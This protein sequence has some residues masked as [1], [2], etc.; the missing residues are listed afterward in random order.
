MKILYHHRTL[1]DGAEGIHIAEMVAAFRSLG[2][3]VHV[4]SLAG[5]EGLPAREEL[6]GRLKGI[7]PSAAY[8][9][10]A[11]ASNVPEY[12]AVRREIRA[13]RPDFLYKRHARLDVGA[14]SAARQ[15]GIPTVLE[16]NCL[17][18]GAHY[19]QFEPE[20]RALTQADVVLAVSTP[21]ARDIERIAQIKAAVIPNG[22]DP[23]RFD[24]AVADRGRI[25]TRYGLGQAL[26]VGWAG[27]MRDWHGLELLL[28]AVAGIA[29]VQLFL[30][31]DG[32]ARAGVE[33]YAATLGVS[34]RL[35][36]TGRVPQEQMPD[37]LAAM[38]IA[39]VASERT[40][41]ASP[42]KLLEYM[43]MER[44]V[45]APRLENIAELI[46]DGRDG[47]L[48]VA[49][50]SD[51]LAS[52]LRRLAVDERLR[53]ALGREARRTVQE[54]RNW[55]SNAERVLA[56]VG[57]TGAAGLQVTRAPSEHHEPIK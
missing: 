7:L 25:R 38:D 27:V 12:F 57:R 52:V 13:L 14:L 39:V 53:S 10:A 5:G 32:P 43:A 31:G 37:H 11:L 50:G 9:L 18:T 34:D 46:T 56:L 28:D 1:A 17:F 26:T 16:V 35:V 47:L 48:F 33:S 51:S 19:Q 49:E 6:V 24:P 41:V 29:G 2:H 15:A 22:A 55:R 4:R 20:R 54:G 36:I 21:L 42:M 44:A 45:V 3:E 30:V 23:Q 8:E 40:R